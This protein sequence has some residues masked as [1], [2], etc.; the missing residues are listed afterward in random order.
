MVLVIRLKLSLRKTM[1]LTIYNNSVEAY[2]CKK[3]GTRHK[4]RSCPAYGKKTICYYKSNHFELGCKSKNK[5]IYK[6]SVVTD[7]KYSDYESSDEFKINEIKS[8]LELNSKQNGWTETVKVTSNILEFK[9]DS[10]SDVNILP[11]SE[12]LKINPKLRLS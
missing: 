4:S 7:K 3:C 11:Y 6:T 10:G 9:L 2:D 8:V 12:Y 1:Q 5:K